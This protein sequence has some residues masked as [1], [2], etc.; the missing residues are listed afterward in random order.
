MNTI[1]LRS[2]NRSR[3]AASC[4]S[5]RAAAWLQTLARPSLPL[6]TAFFV[7]LHRLSLGLSTVVLNAISP[8]DLDRGQDHAL[9]RISLQENRSY[10]LQLKIV[11]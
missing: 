5:I 10:E 1:A 3:L 7:V 8:S 11:L 9:T 6:N 4:P 2:I